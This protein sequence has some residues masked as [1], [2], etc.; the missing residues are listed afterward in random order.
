MRKRLAILAIS[1]SCVSVMQLALLPG[2]VAHSA[3]VE[4][5]PAKKARLSE[6]PA[7][8]KIRFSEVP[9]VIKDKKINSIT[10]ISPAGKILSSPTT[11]I[12]GSWLRVMVPNSK[13]VA[14]IYI[15]RYRMASA[16]GHV[17]SGSYTFTL[18]K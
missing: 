5:V 11:R 12:D 15:V 9:L 1:L 8:I 2:A 7:E 4:T 16:D 10:L 17:I 18:R 13:D 6:I 3:I 14:G